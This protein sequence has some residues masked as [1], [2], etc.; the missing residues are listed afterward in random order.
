[1]ER[2]TQLSK[3]IKVNFYH[4]KAH[5]NIE[6]NE[7][8]DKMAK[9]TNPK[10]PESVVSGIAEAIPMKRLGTIEGKGNIYIDFVEQ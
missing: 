7:L 3:Q 6:G 8:V 5:D 4:V 9:M 1:M 2:Y 10:D